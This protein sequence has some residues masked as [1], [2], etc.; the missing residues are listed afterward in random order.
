M[1]EKGTGAATHGGDG[2]KDGHVPVYYRHND[3][4][5]GNGVYLNRGTEYD[6]LEMVHAIREAIQGSI[7]MTNGLVEL[8]EVSVGPSLTAPYYSPGALTTD[9]DPVGPA[10]V[11][12]ALYI[13]GATAI[14]PGFGGIGCNANISAYQAPVAEAPQ[15]FARIVNNTI[16]GDDGTRTATVGSAAEPNDLFVDAVD[17][18]LSGSHRDTYTVTATLGDNGG[19]QAATTDVDFYRVYLEVGDRLLADISTSGANAPGVTVFGK[20]LKS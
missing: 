3:D 8:V 2:I 1:T 12:P 11:S 7:L 17:T 19:G 4:N 20:S 10:I 5:T 14:Y 9:G 13:E 16:F 18:R 6:E 15:P